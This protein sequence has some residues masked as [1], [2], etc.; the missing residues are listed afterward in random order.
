MAGSPAAH[1]SLAVVQWKPRSTASRR[2]ECTQT[3][4]V[5]PAIVIA[6]TPAVRNIQI[7]RIKC[8]EARLVDHRLS[9][10]RRGFRDDGVA[11]FAAHQ[12]SAEWPIAADRRARAGS[13]ALFELREIG[14]IRA[15]PFAGVDHGYACGARRRQEALYRPNRGAQN[16]DIY[17]GLRNIPQ[18]IE[19]IALHID[20]QQRHPSRH[21]H[22]LQTAVKKETPTAPRKLPARLPV[23]DTVP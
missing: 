17:A 3:S 11:R 10:Q 2:V 7:R 22:A 5:T 15:V 20:D 9:G 12:Q 23:A 14:Q 1:A 6:D 13:A 4:V 18:R 16:T 19:K 8:T 21:G